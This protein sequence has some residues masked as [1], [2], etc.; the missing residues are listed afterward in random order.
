V[1]FEKDVGNY[2]KCVP[3]PSLSMIKEKEHKKPLW[4]L[5][6]FP[7]KKAKVHSIRRASLGLR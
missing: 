2:C 7:G 6:T 3:S 4:Y 5:I 1:C